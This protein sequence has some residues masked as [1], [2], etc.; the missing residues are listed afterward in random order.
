MNNVFYH[1][2]FCFRQK[3]STSN[4]LID[5]NDKIREQ[6]EKGNFT[7][8]IFVD[9]QNFFGTVDHNILI[10]KLNHYGIRR[11]A[12]NCFFFISSVSN[13]IWNIPIVVP[14]KVLF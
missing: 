11:V 1:L 10:Q 5:S 14:L 13:A 2:Q 8:K 6:L 9:L 3:Y 7:C 12:N 4:A